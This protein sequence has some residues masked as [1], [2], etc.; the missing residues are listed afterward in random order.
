MDKK[1]EELAHFDS[2]ARGLPEWGH[3][4]CAGLLRVQG[5]ICTVPDTTSQHPIT[6]AKTV[7]KKFYP[8]LATLV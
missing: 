3:R 2:E 5:K 4:G 8:H 1:Y 7:S 6:G